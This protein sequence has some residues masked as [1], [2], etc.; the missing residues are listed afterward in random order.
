M[1]EIYY[2][3]KSTAGRTGNEFFTFSQNPL[4]QIFRGKSPVVKGLFCIFGITDF[5]V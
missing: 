5:L 3:K 2:T 4:Y 1:Q